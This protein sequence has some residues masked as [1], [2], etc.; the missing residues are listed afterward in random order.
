M[1]N[2]VAEAIKDLAN[3]PA[4]KQAQAEAKEANREIAEAIQDLKGE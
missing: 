4:A 1:K 3:D 2:Q